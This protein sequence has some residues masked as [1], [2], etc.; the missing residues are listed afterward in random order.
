MLLCMFEIDMAMSQ[1]KYTSDLDLI[2]EHRSRR[3]EDKAKSVDEAESPDE[4]IS[5]AHLH[6]IMNGKLVTPF[7]FSRSYR[8]RW[9]Q[10]PRFGQMPSPTC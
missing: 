8:F 10:S 3:R 1:F 6:P 4:A 7:G 5:L 9:R 2:L